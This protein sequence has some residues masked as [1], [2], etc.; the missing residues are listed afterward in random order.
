MHSCYLLAIFEAFLETPKEEMTAKCI[1]LLN[2]DTEYPHSVAALSTWMVTTGNP[3]ALQMEEI[4][5]IL[6]SKPLDESWGALMAV[7]C[8][9]VTPDNTL[10][11][12][13]DWLFENEKGAYL[14][15][16]ITRNPSSST[17]TKEKA[18]KFYKEKEI[19]T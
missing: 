7:A 12:L 3:N 9:S 17:A 5:N 13:A 10:S 4:A 15:K 14:T 8:A 1:E 11:N 18:I 2:T 19:I 16:L 6:M